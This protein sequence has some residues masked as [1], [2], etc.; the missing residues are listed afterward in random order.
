M[1]GPAVAPPSKNDPAKATVPEFDRE[2][3]EI[4]SE[5]PE[6]DREKAQEI[7]SERKGTG[8]PILD[9]DQKIEENLAEDRIEN[10]NK[11]VTDSNLKSPSLEAIYE[12]PG[13][14]RLRGGK[15]SESKASGNK[16]SEEDHAVINDPKTEEEKKE[17]ICTEPVCEKVAKKVP[18]SKVGVNLQQ[19]KTN[20]TDTF[21]NDNRRSMND[22]GRFNNQGMARNAAAFTFLLLRVRTVKT[23]P[24]N[25]Q[26]S[27][28]GV[29][30]VTSGEEER[31]E[32]RPGVL[33]P[34]GERDF[35]VP[36]KS[37]GMATEAG[38]GSNGGDMKGDLSSMK[39][40][41]TRGNNG[42]VSSLNPSRVGSPAMKIRNVDSRR[43]H[44]CGN[45][46][47]AKAV[48]ETP[49][50]RAPVWD[51]VSKEPVG[52]HWNK[53]PTG[54]QTWKK[55]GG[56]AVGPQPQPQGGGKGTQN[57]RKE[58]AE[59]MQQTV[60][61][62]EKK[63]PAANLWQEEKRKGPQRE[64]FRGETSG[65]GMEGAKKSEGENQ[66]EDLKTKEGWKEVEGD[67]RGIRKEVKTKNVN[68]GVGRGSYYEVLGTDVDGDGDLYDTSKFKTDWDP[69]DGGEWQSLTCNMQQQKQGA[70]SS[71]LCRR[72]HGA[73]GV[74]SRVQR[75]S[76]RLNNVLNPFRAGNNNSSRS[77]SARVCSFERGWWLPVWC[78]LRAECADEG[79]GRDGHLPEASF[80]DELLLQQYLAAAL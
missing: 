15:S 37:D 29:A 68:Q 40:E 43:E 53:V 9:T 24:G 12:A 18:A 8:D 69:G 21:E 52:M 47:M 4:R 22:K 63:E 55:E 5:R 33:N 44:A 59:V 57:Q 10:G 56:P 50:R 26:R 70:V 61:N 62:Q 38:K 75:I 30:K 51:N 28:Q 78:N 39:M 73:M 14:E 32:V 54:G 65:V 49:N 34:P 77:G 79:R 20:G 7:R 72:H 6:F 45:A 74:L 71:R 48:A 2:N 80:D 46:S 67:R 76:C 13:P 16:K 58:A 25:L 41:N 23:C 31:K 36:A 17:E 3:Q 35:F 1:A 11:N 42:K 27:V 64:L 19:T 66:R 60:Q